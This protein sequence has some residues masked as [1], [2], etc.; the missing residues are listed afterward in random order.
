MVTLDPVAG[1]L[2]VTARPSGKVE[3]VFLSDSNDAAAFSGDSRWLLVNALGLYSFYETGTWQLHHVV[4]SRNQAGSQG[5][6][7]LSQDGE[8]AALEQ[9]GQEIDIINIPQRRSLVTLRPPK[10]LKTMR[11]LF[12]NDA[13]KLYVHTNQQRLFRWELHHLQS[14]L[15]ALGLGW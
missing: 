2:I 13:R 12:S 7:T 1:K 6:F 8:F 11:M 10:M 15:T 5:T 9:E 3:T 4:P 14:E